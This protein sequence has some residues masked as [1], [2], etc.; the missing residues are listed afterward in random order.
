LWIGLA[1]IGALTPIKAVISVGVGGDRLLLTRLGRRALHA[2]VR[3]RILIGVHGLSP[4]LT[5]LLSVQAT[6][7]IGVE[8]DDV[9]TGSAAIKVSA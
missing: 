2:A 3:A 4:W 6:V 7:T 8:R 1:A 9:G 5:H